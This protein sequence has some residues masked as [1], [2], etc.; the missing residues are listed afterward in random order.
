MTLSNIENTLNSSSD[1]KFKL[2]LQLLLDAINDWPEQVELV[3]DYF[4]Q[5]KLKL[6]IKTL[7]KNEIDNGLKTLNLVKNA[8]VHESLA[9][10]D[11]VFKMYPSKTLDEI[12]F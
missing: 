10:I 2:A 6:A 5:I 11:E 7:N 4:Y 3:E 9:S 8:W 12:F 1:P